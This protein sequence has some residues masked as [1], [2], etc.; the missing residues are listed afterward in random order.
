MTCCQRHLA[1][2]AWHSGD[3]AQTPPRTRASSSYAMPTGLSPVSNV[4]S[5]FR[6]TLINTAKRHQPI[7]TE[8]PAQRHSR[9]YRDRCQKFELY[10]DV[11]GTYHF[12]SARLTV[13]SN[14]VPSCAPGRGDS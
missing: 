11:L 9:R 14:G 7:R 3:G 1:L 12:A 2:V 6:L 5:L 10:Y 8:I 13:C 4:P